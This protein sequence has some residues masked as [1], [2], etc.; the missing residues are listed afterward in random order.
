VSSSPLL[1]ELHI[2]VR[3]AVRLGMCSTDMN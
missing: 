1:N 3:Q 2:L